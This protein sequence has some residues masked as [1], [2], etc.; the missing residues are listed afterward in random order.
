MIYKHSYV[1]CSVLVVY[2]L[3]LFCKLNLLEMLHIT[4][5]LRIVC[6]VNAKHTPTRDQI[7]D[8]IFISHSLQNHILT[9]IYQITVVHKNENIRIPVSI[10]CI[11]KVVR[12]RRIGQLLVLTDKHVNNTNTTLS[13]R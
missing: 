13:K 9:L 12:F 11:V 8:N 2:W 4:H 7:T 5:S 3:F 1:L 10:N 6:V